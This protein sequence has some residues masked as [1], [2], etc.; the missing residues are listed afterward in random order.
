MGHFRS[1]MDPGVLVTGRVSLSV[2]ILGKRVTVTELVESLFD[3][4][5]LT[6]YSRVWLLITKCQA[7]NR[8]CADHSKYS[9]VSQS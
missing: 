1:D 4:I 5:S 9:P 3:S 8:I 2:L 7:S 6:L